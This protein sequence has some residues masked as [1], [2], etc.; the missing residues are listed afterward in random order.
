VET[1]IHAAMRIIGQRLTSRK[2]RIFPSAAPDRCFKKD[3]IVLDETSNPDLTVSVA[4]IVTRNTI[5]LA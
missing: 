3:L 2:L 1:V 4:K 5:R